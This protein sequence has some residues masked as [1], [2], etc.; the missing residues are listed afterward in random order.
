MVYR[1]QPIRRIPNAKILL[2]TESN[3]FELGGRVTDRSITCGYR[4]FFLTGL[5]RAK[6]RPLSGWWIV[7]GYMWLDKTGSVY[8]RCAPALDDLVKMAELCGTRES[9]LDFWLSRF[10]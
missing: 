9:T 2:V 3:E 8:H 1:N 7:H 6:T 10:L 4:S 5:P